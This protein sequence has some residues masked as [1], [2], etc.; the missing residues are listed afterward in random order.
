MCGV[1]GIYGSDQVAYELYDAMLM[2]QHRGQDACGMGVYDGKHFNMHKELGL[3]RDVF[4]EETFK[5]LG[6]HIGIGHLRYPTV[7]GCRVLDAQ[8][9]FR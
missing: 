5:D 4:K 3:T 7:G 1:V 2:L 8:P 9:F 6:G